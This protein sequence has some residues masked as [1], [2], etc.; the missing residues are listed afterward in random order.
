MPARPTHPFDTPNRARRKEPSQDEIVCGQS[1]VVKTIVD[2]KTTYHS[3]SILCAPR[4]GDADRS[5]LG[6]I[7]LRLELLPLD[8][9]VD[10]PTHAAYANR[11][12]RSPASCCEVIA[13][14]LVRPFPTIASSKS[15]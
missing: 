1:G 5:P 13:S 15:S 6:N 14:W 11:N 12:R 7:G 4:T 3:K 2:A 8:L 10:S 9:R